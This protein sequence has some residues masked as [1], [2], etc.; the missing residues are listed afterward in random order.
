MGFDQ[1]RDGTQLSRSL[2]DTV[3]FLPRVIKS[4][5]LTRNSRL[6]VSRAA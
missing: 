5:V 4:A 6:S 1:R 2:P 3:G